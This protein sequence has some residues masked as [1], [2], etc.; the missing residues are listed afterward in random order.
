MK[1]IILLCICYILSGLQVIA[2]ELSEFGNF[3]N[4]EINLKECSFDKEAAAVM[5][6]HEA[7]ST[8]DD[9][10]R[11]ITTH[12]IKIKILSDKGFSAANVSIPFYRENSFETI[13][14][15]EGITFNIDEAGNVSKKNV[16]QK[17]IY[18]QNVNERFGE[19]VFAFPVVKAGSI[20]EYK[21]ESTMR[22]YGGLEE[23]DFQERI[24]VLLN[25]YTLVVLPNSEFAYRINKSPELP[26]VIRNEKG[27]GGVYFEMKNIP[28][29]T[30][31]PFM[32]SR[33]DYLQKVIFQLSGF[34]RGNDFKDSYM[35]SWDEMS[36][37]LI[38]S[39]SFA[40]QLN[41]NIPGTDDFIN[42]VKILTSPEQKM[43]AIYEF[44]RSNMKWNNLY[45]KYAVDG[46]KDAWQKKSGTSGDINLLLVNLLKNA[47]LDAFP[48]LV[49]ER[50][51]GKVDSKYPFLDQF[52]SVFA[53]VIINE[54]KYFLDA[55]DKLCPSHLTPSSIL[56]TTAFIVNRKAYG[57][58]DIVN[59]TAAY[60][61]LIIAKL[62]VSDAGLLSGEVSI[63]SAD[64]ARDKK[65]E[66]Y[67]N[68][69][70][71]KGETAILFDGADFT[72]SD[73]QFVNLEK[74][75]LPLEQNCKI[76]GTMNKAGDFYFLPLNFFTGFETNP[77]ITEK[78]FSNINFGYK[79]NI[80]MNM[81]VQ[82]PANYSI[83]E[84]PK[85]IKFTDPDKDILFWRSVSYDKQTNTITS[86]IQIDFKKSLYGPEVYPIIKEMYQKI[87]QYLK[88]PLLI[89]KKP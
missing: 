66:E 24:P 53:C 26:I 39:P 64:Y 10:Y 76:S 45:S 16:S 79:R 72:V 3:S 85:T 2:Q 12:H 60:K 47:S 19:V 55:T 74:D 70:D 11:L 89:K 82:L 21:Y 8:Y 57:L 62:K 65:V 41:K 6:L 83:E 30:D 63:K 73:K 54:K 34:N 87:S 33:K 56:N 22:H 4:E 7:F 52:N 40:G 44:V 86:I 61:E 78:R 36:K 32:D 68:T 25:K 59:D 75:S 18:T 71:K 15:I 28:G 13:A 77:F 88:E 46:V 48:M 14:R 38:G 69:K 42:Q 35:T 29:L 23:W 50:F 67:I 9:R 27:I 43:T 58:I 20:L 31:E 80:S 37:E 49:S 5:L 81:F 17:S 1:R 84:L 51:H